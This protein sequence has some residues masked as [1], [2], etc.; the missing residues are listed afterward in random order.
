L[1]ILVTLTTAT[2]LVD[3][4]ITVIVHAITNFSEP[5]GPQFIPLNH[6][7]V[8]PRH[9]GRKIKNEIALSGCLHFV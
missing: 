7:G 6:A 3:L 2:K 4:T 1:A 8:P 9:R 5:I